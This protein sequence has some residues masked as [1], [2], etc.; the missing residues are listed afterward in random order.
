M[1]VFFAYINLNKTKLIRSYYVVVAYDFVWNF[2]KFEFLWSFFEKFQILIDC[3]LLK[4]I[5]H[6]SSVNEY[7]YSGDCLGM[8]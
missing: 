3:F 7:L 6:V 4:L 8:R 5:V 2:L 1:Q